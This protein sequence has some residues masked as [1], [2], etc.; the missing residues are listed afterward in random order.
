[1]YNYPI[2]SIK[3]RNKYNYNRIFTFSFLLNIIQLNFIEYYKMGGYI[4]YIFY[5]LSEILSLKLFV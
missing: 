2:T 1:M 3:Y 4:I 5:Y